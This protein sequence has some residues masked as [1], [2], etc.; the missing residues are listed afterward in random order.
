M[1]DG[2]SEKNGKAVKIKHG[3]LQPLLDL[4]TMVFS[5]LNLRKM[6]YYLN[7]IY[8]WVGV[9]LKFVNYLIETIF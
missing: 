7:R 6:D 9:Q 5:D 3:L 4:F 8:H 2:K 1:E